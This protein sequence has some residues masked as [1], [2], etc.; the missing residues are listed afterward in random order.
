[1]G[2]LLKGTSLRDAGGRRGR[3]RSRDEEDRRGAARPEWAV[4]GR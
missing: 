4:P 2:D 1:M 3:E